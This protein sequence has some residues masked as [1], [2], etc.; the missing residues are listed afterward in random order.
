[1]TGL[2]GLEGEPEEGEGARS[3]QR[4]NFPIL[5]K[6]N[7]AGT[8]ETLAISGCS[9]RYRKIRIYSKKV[10]KFCLAGTKKTRKQNWNRK[11][12]KDARVSKLGKV[13]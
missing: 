9:R 11:R 12:K 5:L 4:F 6:G 1:M 13:C 7:K 8:E 2:S 10:I 3:K